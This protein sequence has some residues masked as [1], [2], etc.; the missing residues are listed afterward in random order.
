MALGPVHTVEQ[1]ATGEEPVDRRSPSL[2]AFLFLI[3]SA[4]ER[5]AAVYRITMWLK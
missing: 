4:V 3:I 5:R 1:E 2:L